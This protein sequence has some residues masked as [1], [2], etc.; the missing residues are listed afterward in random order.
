ME[1]IL[2]YKSFKY[3]PDEIV[4]IHY[5]YN[6]MITPVK[7]VERVGNKYLITHNIES[8]KIK[9]APD[10]YIKTTEVIDKYRKTDF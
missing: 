5:W 10:E 1:Y 6:Y 2:E 4:L 9:N 7:I 8:S 3:E